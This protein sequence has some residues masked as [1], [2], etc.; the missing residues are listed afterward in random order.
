MCVYVCVARQLRQRWKW[1]WRTY[2]VEDFEAENWR[3]RRFLHITM[4]GG[5]TEWYGMATR[6]EC[7]RIGSDTLWWYDDVKLADIGRETERE[8]AESG[9]ERLRTNAWKYAC[10]VDGFDTTLAGDVANI[11]CLAADGRTGGNETHSERGWRPWGLIFQMV[12]TLE[13]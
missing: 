10:M 5:G 8:R 13:Y 4:R 11:K 1:W 7:A 9:W 2:W 6:L 3:S 12:A